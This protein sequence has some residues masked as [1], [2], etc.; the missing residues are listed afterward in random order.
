MNPEEVE[1]A[2]N[3]HD[4]VRMSLVKARKNPL[5]GAIVVADVVLREPD[6][7]DEALKTDILDA[8]RARLDRHKV[9]AMLRFVPNLALTAGG[10]LSRANG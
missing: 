8:C 10:K 2:L 5:T 3:A 7:A 4:A 9:P 1:A 6:R